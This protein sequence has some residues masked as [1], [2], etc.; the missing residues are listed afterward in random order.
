MSDSLRPHGI[1]QAPPSVGCSRQ[2]YWSELPFPSPGDPPNP[3][4]KPRSPRLQ[5]DLQ[6]EP[7]GNPQTPGGEIEK[8]EI[9][10]PPNPLH[11]NSHEGKHVYY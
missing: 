10:Q 5:A 4:I 7:P 11:K 2:E 1:H 8:S 9:F 6:A 3:G